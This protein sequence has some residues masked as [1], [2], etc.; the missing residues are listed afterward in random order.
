MYAFSN[1]PAT[2]KSGFEYSGHEQ[3][4]ECYCFT[5]DTCYTRTASLSIGRQVS[6]MLSSTGIVARQSGNSAN[7]PKVLP[8]KTRALVYNTQPQDFSDYPV[9]SRRGLGGSRYVFYRHYTC[10]RCEPPSEVT[11]R[12]CLGRYIAVQFV[13]IVGGRYRILFSLKMLHGKI[14]AGYVHPCLLPI[15]CRACGVFK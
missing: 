11:G 6:M 3:K 12:N 1:I 4:W 7:V 14:I 5:F 2:N 10:F 8:D 15:T 9:V 13:G